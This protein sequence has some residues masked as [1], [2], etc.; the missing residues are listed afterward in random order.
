MIFEINTAEHYLFKNFLKYR[1]RGFLSTSSYNLLGHADFTLADGS[2][3][4]C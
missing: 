4:M 1:L 3:V 2:F